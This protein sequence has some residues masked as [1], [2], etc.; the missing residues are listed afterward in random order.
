MKI[1]EFS[2][3]KADKRAFKYKK[4]PS[5]DKYAENTNIVF[6]MNHPH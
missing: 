1:Q 2:K 5:H 4:C 3:S 6:S